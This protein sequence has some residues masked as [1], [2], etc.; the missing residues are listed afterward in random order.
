MSWDQPRVI[1]IA[2]GF[3]RYIKAAVQTMSNVELKTYTLYEGDVLH[4]ENQYSPLPEKTSKKSQAIEVEKWEYKMGMECI[5]SN[6]QL[7]CKCEYW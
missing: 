4:V 1:L 7:R 5:L 3:D 2:Q 6:Q